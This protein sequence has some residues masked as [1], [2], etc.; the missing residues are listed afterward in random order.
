M[1]LARNHALKWAIIFVLTTAAISGCSASQD[2]PAA[3]GGELDF[4]MA[5]VETRIAAQRTD[6]ASIHEIQSYILTQTWDMAGRVPTRTP[7]TTVATPYG[8]PSPEPT[9]QVSTQEYYPAPDGEFTAIVEGGTRLLV[10][11]AAG[12]RELFVAEEI[13]GV[14]WFPDG[15]HIAMGRIMNRDRIE[16]LDTQIW[17]IDAQDGSAEL[18]GGGYE[19]VVSPDGTHVSYKAGIP[20]ADA[21]EIGY[22]LGISALTHDREETEFLSQDEFVGLPEAGKSESFYPTGSSGLPSGGLWLDAHRL[23]V[24]MRW[25]CRDEP[26]ANGVYLLDV[27]SLSATKYMDFSSAEGNPIPRFTAGHPA[28]L[29]SID[30]LNEQRGWALGGILGSSSHVFHTRDGGHVW[31]DVTPLEPNLTGD[32]TEKSATAAFFDSRRAWA[33]YSPAEAEQLKSLNLWRTSNSG[34]T[35]GVSSVH[36]ASGF[37]PF[38]QPLSLVF[39]SPDEGWLMLAVDAGMSHVYVELHHTTD[40]GENWEALVVPPGDD[41]SGNLHV[42]S[43]TGMDFFPNGTGLVTFSRGP[44]EPVVIDWTTDGGRRWQSQHLPPPEDCPSP[45]C[46][47]GLVCESYQPTLF[48]G[49]HGK[50]AVECLTDPGSLS[51][52]SRS[53]LYTT[54]DGGHSWSIDRFPGGEL[55]FVTQSVAWAINDGIH[56]TKDGG[57]NWELRGD[58]PWQG[59]FDFISAQVGWA[60]A[61]IQ[62]A[63]KLLMTQDGGATWVELDA[64]IVP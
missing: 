3:E 18:L 59:R 23:L 49:Q 33:V 39:T 52:T 17:I 47:N 57:V 26:D 61:E 53:Y 40:G 64:L 16:D 42:H 14:S 21:C 54:D 56:Q 5:D 27:T 20:F 37:C 55:T 24:P 38:M 19:P 44:Q 2:R 8:T 12:E 29:H 45:D 51:S 50:L 6:I 11:G 48:S 58:P 35:W 28:P 7:G 10:A 62:A 60:V 22:S 30:M 34:D 41:Y 9:S 36:C 13:A 25:A 43:Q 32:P 1:P 15:R 63:P 4:R 46:F 31:S